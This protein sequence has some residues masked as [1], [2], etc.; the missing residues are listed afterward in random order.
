LLE[1]FHIV[2]KPQKKVGPGGKKIFEQGENRVL[3]FLYTTMNND[4]DITSSLDN[5]RLIVEFD[6]CSYNPI[7][8][9]TLTADKSRLKGITTIHGPE[10]SLSFTKWSETKVISKGLGREI[11]G[12]LVEMGFEPE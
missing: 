8:T 9:H 2:W 10:W 11:W 3:T 4:L 6:D 5:G 7:Q 1:R 12:V